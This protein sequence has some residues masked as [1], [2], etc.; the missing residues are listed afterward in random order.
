MNDNSAP[1]QRLN[2][3][4]AEIAQLIASGMAVESDSLDVWRKQVN[5]AAA[6]MI[7]LY[8]DG[9]LPRAQLLESRADDP[10]FARS[11]RRRIEQ[12]SG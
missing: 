12:L 5:R 7:E 8:G 9:A 4:L 2:R 11:V 10:S 3:T 1:E 6:L